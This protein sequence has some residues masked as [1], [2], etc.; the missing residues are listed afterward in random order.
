[1]APQLQETQ[2]IGISELYPPASLSASWWTITHI[3]NKPSAFSYDPI[4]VAT[5]I[6]DFGIID[7]FGKLSTRRGAWAWFHDVWTWSAKVLEY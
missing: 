1:M 6:T 5:S 4:Y 2:E 7:I 3:S